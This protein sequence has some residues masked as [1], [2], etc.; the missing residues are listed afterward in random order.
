MMPQKSPCEGVSI[1]LK[2]TT[3]GDL[4]MPWNPGGEE[5]IKH[6]VNVLPQEQDT[7]LCHGACMA[8]CIMLYCGAHSSAMKFCG[9][10]VKSKPEESVKLY[11]HRKA[12]TYLCICP[13][14][15]FCCQEANL[16]LSLRPIERVYILFCNSECKSQ[17]HSQTTQNKWPFG[18][19]HTYVMLSYTHCMV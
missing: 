19:C 12:V 8:S 17:S 10:W 3:P 6:E 9:T 15:P 1:M 16:F 18:G 11:Y 7:V 2:S 4:E 13:I 5:N 14:L